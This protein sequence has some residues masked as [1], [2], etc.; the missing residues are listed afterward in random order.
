MRFTT[1]GKALALAAVL[2]AGTS[3]L[4]YAAPPIAAQPPLVASGGPVSVKF[5]GKDA[6]LVSEL[7]FFGA[8]N[9]TTNP[10]APGTGQFLF[11]NTAGGGVS[12]WDGS[13]PAVT[14]AARFNYYDTGASFSWGQP[15]YFGIFVPALNSGL[16][17]WF[18]TGDGIDPPNPNSRIHAKL[19]DLGGG[20]VV[21]GFEDL[22]REGV[23]V[24][25]ACKVDPMKV[26]WDY[27][28]NIF[29]IRGATTT[30]EPV[31]MAL[32]GTGL[33]GLAGVARRRRK[34]RMQEA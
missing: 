23:L 14:G 12:A 31:S 7:W 10:P 30:P 17:R 28:D 3:T 20:E 9:P 34:N 15:L 22:C 5:N 1:A 11:R 26:D 8:A 16:G 29:Q 4:G 33:F 19:T 27:N 13:A 25:D 24:G 32:L 18:Y 21:L 2:T 6:E